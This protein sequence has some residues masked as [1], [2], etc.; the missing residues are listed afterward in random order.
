MSTSTQT[1]AGTPWKQGVK[2]R[3]SVTW[4]LYSGGHFFWSDFRS[5]WL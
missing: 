5:V 4:R 1:L 3:N 2:R